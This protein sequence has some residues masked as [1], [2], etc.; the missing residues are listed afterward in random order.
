MPRMTGVRYIKF[1]GHTETIRISEPLSW[2]RDVPAQSTE[3]LRRDLPMSTRRRHTRESACIMNERV[4]VRWAAL[5]VWTPSTRANL[6]AVSRYTTLRNRRSLIDQ[7]V[8]LSFGVDNLVV[9][10]RDVF[11][12]YVCWHAVSCRESRWR[13]V[14]LRH[15]PTRHA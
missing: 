8:P 2:Y 3:S 13:A 12:I 15:D 1:V 11:K 9:C 14:W 7:S 6:A 5:C 10:F 4:Q